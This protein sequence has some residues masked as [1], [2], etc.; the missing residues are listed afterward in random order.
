ME[1]NSSIWWKAWR[2]IIA[3]DRIS[4]LYMVTT[5]TRK[6]ISFLKL[7]SQDKL[8]RSK[9]LL[10]VVDSCTCSSSWRNAC[11]QISKQMKGD[12][13]NCIKACSCW[14]LITFHIQDYVHVQISRGI[15]RRQKFVKPITKCHI[16]NLVTNSKLICH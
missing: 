6:Q 16:K 14:D 11:L 13:T 15:C 7:S 3:K 8:I 9:A 1:D 10:I 5:L 2:I 4:G 12:E